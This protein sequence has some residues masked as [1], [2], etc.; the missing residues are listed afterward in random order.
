MLYSKENVG[1]NNLK[2]INFCLYIPEVVTERIKKKKSRSSSSSNNN[3]IPPKLPLKEV[4]FEK[5]NGQ[6]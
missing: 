3:N 2:Y 1:Q 6:I 5:E 4:M